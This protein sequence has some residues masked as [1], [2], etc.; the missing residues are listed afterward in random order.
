MQKAHTNINWVN[1]PSTDTPINETNLNAM[2]NSIDVIDDRVITLDTTKAN[3][4]DLLS[5]VSDVQLDNETGVLTVTYKNGVIQTFD[6]KLEKIAV[7]FYYDGNPSSPNYQK[8]IITLDDG[9]QQFVDMTAL[10]TQYEFSDTATIDFTVS[11]SGGVSATVKDGS[12]TRAKINPDYLAQI[13]I[14]V[15]SAASS[16]RQSA[17]SSESSGTYAETSEAWAVGQKNGQDVTPQDLQYQNN[18]KYYAEQS[19]LIKDGCDSVLVEVIEA[20]NQV[21]FAVN[22]TTGVLEY[23]SNA[24]YNFV[25]NQVTGNLEWEVVG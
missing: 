13:D 23:S 15:E 2:D 20:A 4:V 5:T 17:V 14:S 8:L 12:I 9:T 11:Q 10:I 21:V 3:Q 18:S 19:Q 16:A 22:F 25:I 1:L 6:T 24:I 7:N